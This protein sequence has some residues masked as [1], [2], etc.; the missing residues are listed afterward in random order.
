V[1]ALHKVGA[2]E[3]RFEMFEGPLAAQ[4]IVRPMRIAMETPDQRI[5]RVPLCLGGDE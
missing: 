4:L 5:Q 2:G 3:G 1:A